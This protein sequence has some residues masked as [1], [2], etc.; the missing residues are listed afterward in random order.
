MKV[1]GFNSDLRENLIRNFPFFLSCL[2]LLIYL[3]PNIFFWNEAKLLIHDNLDSNI[4]WYKLLAGSGK[5]FSP[6]QTPIPALMNG[7]PRIVL[8]TEYNV[9]IL[10]YFLFPAAVAYS[11]NII[12]IHL[13]AFL[14]MRLLAKRYFS[15]KNNDQWILNGVSLS[16]SLLPFWPPGGLSMAGLPLLLYAFL[17]IYNNKEAISDWL[18]LVF[19]P[20]YS[21]LFFSASFFLFFMFSAFLWRAFRHK[22]IKWKFFAALC[23]VS[24]IYILVEYRLFSNALW[25][26]FVHH[27]TEEIISQGEKVNYGN[28]NFKGVIGTSF[29][30]FIQ[31]HYH[32]ASMHFPFIILV[33]ILSVFFIENKYKRKIIAGLFILAGLISFTYKIIDWTA[34][35]LIKEKILF[36]RYFHIRFYIL[37]PLVWFCIFGIAMTSVPDKK[38]VKYIF[39]PA[40]LLQTAYCMLSPEGNLE[41][42][43]KRTYLSGESGSEYASFNNFYQEKFFD[44]IKIQLNKNIKS[45][46]T[47]CIGFTPAIAQFNGFQ[48]L[49]AYLPLYP[50][51]YKKKFREI[52]EGELVKDS[53]KCSYFDGWGNKCYIFLGEKINDNM[54]HDLSININALK[55]MNCRYIFS[56]YIIGNADELNLSLLFEKSADDHKDGIQKL[57]LYQ[58]SVDR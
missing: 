57:Y 33:G 9:N 41:N 35:D 19:F 42:S 26:D 44:E 16:F 48:T 23:M 25:G 3:S 13:I 45:F 55:D 11:I 5:I 1:S 7:A 51:S 2:I 6:N 24:G 39:Y 36:L 27:H 52:I 21:D 56:R 37:F 10:L 58:I 53:S 54:I 22:E 17:N 28:I 34:L 4:I 14:G 32:S 30:H 8:G 20:F 31:G 47:V 46:N 40:I 15:D 18:I 38:I 12:L 50:L 43:F 29:L 49:D